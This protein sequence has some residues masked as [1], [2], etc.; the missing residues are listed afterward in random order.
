MGEV[1]DSVGKVLK[2]DQN[3]VNTKDTKVTKE[4]NYFVS[5]VPFVFNSPGAHVHLTL[6]TRTIVKPS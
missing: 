2:Q 5:F 6:F 1:E 4:K 3:R